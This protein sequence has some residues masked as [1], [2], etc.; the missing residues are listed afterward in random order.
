MHFVNRFVLIVSLV[1]FN[2]ICGWSKP[3]Y[4][5][6]DD[7]I[8]FPD[9]QKEETFVPKMRKKCANGYCEDADQYP[10]KLVENSLRMRDD[11]R[12]V[13]GEDFNGD[14]LLS[15]RKSDEQF[16][17]AS[18]SQLIFPKVAK[19]RKNQEKFI[20]NHGGHR[21]GIRIEVCQREGAPCLPYPREWKT[22]C[23][24]KYG[25]RRLL[26]IS[27]NGTLE[28]DHFLLPLHCCCTFK[29]LILWNISR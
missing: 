5:F 10:E 2:F 13:F 23:K 18:K 21:Q 19:N 3:T 27:H 28:T 14:S 12:Y 17:C 6:S 22:S 9:D 8:F 1:E 4:K 7:I 20:V 29:P 24:Q 16:V 25:Y 11:F 26:S 15:D